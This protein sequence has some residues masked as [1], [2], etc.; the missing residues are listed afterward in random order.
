MV[1]HH[2]QHMVIFSQLQQGHAQ[3]RRLVQI[4]R[5][6]HLR[7]HSRHQLRF[8]DLRP[9][10]LDPCLGQH[11]LPQVL[12]LLDQMGAQ[13]LVTGQQAVE[14]ALQ[15][16]Q[17]QAPVQTQGTGDV[18]SGAAG[19]QLPEKPLALLGVGQRQALAVLT[20]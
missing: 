19:V 7:F 14:A 20:D 15:C 16:R 6:R 9:L 1:L 13:T 17:V 18:V 5:L 2:H 12:A 10:N 11:S 3:Q 4:E 8:I